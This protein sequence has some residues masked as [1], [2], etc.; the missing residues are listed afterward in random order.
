ML[1]NVLRYAN[2]ILLMMF[3]NSC[4]DAEIY[5]VGNRV[6]VDYVI[7]PKISFK[8][9]RIYLDKMIQMEEYK[10]PEKRVHY[11]K[12]VNIDSIDTK[13]IYFK[14]ILKKCI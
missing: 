12:L 14:K 1:K 5:K 9:I 11:D 3:I 4:N 7:E 13:R 10:V 8:I 2:L 6:T